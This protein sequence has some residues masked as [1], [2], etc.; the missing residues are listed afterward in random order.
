MYHFREEYRETTKQ[1]RD[2]LATE[3]WLDTFRSR[4]VGTSVQAAVEDASEAA[5]RF[6]EWSKTQ[7]G[8][9]E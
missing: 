6:V 5:K 1:Q 4:L 8:E 9:C 2:R 3:L 7:T